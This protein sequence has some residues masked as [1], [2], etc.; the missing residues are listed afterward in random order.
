MKRSLPF[1]LLLLYLTIFSSH[2]HAQEVTLQFQVNMSY[3]IEAGNFDSQSEFVDVAG[4]F[5]NWGG[6]LIQ[7]QDENQDSVYSVTVDGFTVG[8]T[9]EYKFRINGQWDGREEFPG[10]GNNRSYTVEPGEN[11]ISVWY[12]NE[13]DPDGPPAADFFTPS[14]DVFTNTVVQFDNRSTGNITS[15][16]W[17][18]EGGVPATSGQE[19]PVVRYSTTGSFDVQLVASNESESDTLLV[20]DYITV[21]ERETGDT[22]WWN[23]TVF[24]EIFVRSFYDSSG[25]GIGDF[26]G[27]TQKLD[28]LND[29]DPSTDS[30]LGITGIWLMP[31]NESPTYHGYDVIDYRSINPDYGTMEDFKEFLDAAHERG[32]KVII[33]YVMN[34][35]S[36]EHLWFQKSAA[37]DPHYRDFYRWSDTNPGYSGPWGQQVWHNSH[38]GQHFDEYYYGLFWSGMPDLNYD[39]PAVK[40][41]M[42]AISDF[43]INEIGVDGFRQDAVI[44]I[45]E[46][47][48]ILKNTPET[49]Q[50]W[51]DFN[52]NLKAANPEAF[53][54][55]EAWEPTDIALQYVTDD[56]L[57]YVFEFDL[58][59]A[60][61]NGVNNENAEP[62]LS[63]MQVVYDEYPFLQF[64]TFLTNHDQDRVMNVLGQDIDKAKV[65]ASLYLTLPGI[66]YL[67]YGEEV[68][69]LG[70]KPDEDIRLPMQWSS[71]P[72]AGF[73]EGSPWRSPNSNF[74]EYNVEVMEDDE[75]SLLNHY[76]ELIRFRSNHP[77]MQTGE[78]EAAVTSRND[79]IAFFRYD[80]NLD[81]TKLIVINLG[82][83]EITDLSLDHSNSM[84][85]ESDAI[86]SYDNL[87]TGNRNS[88]NA[89]PSEAGYTSQILNIE[90]RSTNIYSPVVF[91]LSTEE[92]EQVRDFELH[93]NYPNPFNPATTISFYLPQ[94]EEVTLT[95]FDITGRR[96]ATLVDQ[97]MNAGI[98]NQTFDASALS[99]GIYFYRLEAGSFSDVQKM[100]LIK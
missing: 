36:T 67:Y 50:F 91:S 65:A 47:G 31:I 17:T 87:L 80:E 82:D 66:P 21:L 73:T 44:Y 3:Q 90:P 59:Q 28:Y 40:D 94:S 49:L 8:E 33:D 32:I 2:L 18:F 25:D 37:G 88:G 71:E 75:N 78:Y 84:L 57:D 20:E 14:R 56:R 10:T 74:A 60:I 99:S 19:N 39:N 64:G 30:D 45:H 79:V 69:M 89:G 5:N 98:H 97:P 68:G 46:D 95:V 81:D 6:D 4:T 23:K 62:I 93:Q 15:W 29:G 85:V 92:P 38:D 34:H 86:Y 24:Y 61:L 63:H 9:I 11:V 12:N 41:S 16:K 7:L 53:A 54:V 43:W 26:K 83:S 58:A 13:V 77:Q 70:Q 48:E 100:T 76:K 96:V 72:N 35:T 1:F 51:Q 52:A 22:H 42:F 55:G 27:L